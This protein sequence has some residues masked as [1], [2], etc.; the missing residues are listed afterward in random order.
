MLTEKD[1]TLV[2]S[3]IPLLE[4]A[5][6]AITE[7]FYN[8]MFKHNPELKD[9]FN[10]SNQHTGKQKVAL[11]EAI[12][13]YAKNIE[14]LAA[15]TTAVERIAQK[16]T[17]F[18]IQPDHYNIVGHHLLATLREL[19]PDAFTA[20]IEQAWANAYQFLAE[21]FISRE[22]ELYTQRANTKGGWRGKRQFKVI[23]KLDESA[24]VTSFIFAPIDNCDV[25]DYQV[26]QYLG[27]ELT[28][29]GAQNVEIRQY[30]LSNKP[31]GKT[32]RISVKREQGQFPG[33]VSNHLHDNVKVGD[34]VDIHA[35][36]GDFFFVDR[37]SPVVLISAGV[38]VTPMQAMLEQMSDKQHKQK[39]HYI[40]ACENN[41]QHSF[42]HRVLELCDKHAWQHN[43]WYKDKIN[44]EANIHQGFIDFTSLELPTD[45]G[46]FYM[47]GPVGFMQFAKTS[48][49]KLGICESRIHYEVFGP[50]ANL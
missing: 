17:S 19:A 42:K 39:V 36:A 21:I 44:D 33:L 23:E 18:N 31:N 30:S 35:P 6:S 4:E 10:M 38:G 24:L 12:A 7:Y 49:V 45:T 43:T 41:E 50:H 27:I 48:L 28:P 46:H 20:E 22:D 47:C 16:H 34:L 32:Y 11:F 29:N 2:K 5:G 9:I 37:Q 40:H 13:A 3:T 1:I 26:G 25:I 14:N 8:R 15:L